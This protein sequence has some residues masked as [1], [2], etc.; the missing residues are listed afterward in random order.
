MFGL[1]GV[2]V[3]TLFVQVYIMIKKLEADQTNQHSHL[4]SDVLIAVVYNVSISLHVKLYPRIKVRC[5]GH[6]C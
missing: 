1:G 3:V 4:S 5:Q 6:F 2:K